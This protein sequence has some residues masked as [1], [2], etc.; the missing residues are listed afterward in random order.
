LRD[1]NP[2]LM[3][4]FLTNGARSIP[5]L[6]SIDRKSGDVL[7]T[8]GPRPKAALDLLA[9][10]MSRAIEK[11]VISENIQRWYLADHGRSLQA[12]IAELTDRWARPSLAKAA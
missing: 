12:E 11:P 7:G 2:E 3:D 4:R 6:I 1:E 8:W 5:K 10:Q 9:E